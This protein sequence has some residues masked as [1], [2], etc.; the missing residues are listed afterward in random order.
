MLCVE[1]PVELFEILEVFS[2]FYDDVNSSELGTN[3]FISN[4]QLFSLSTVIK[5]KSLQ[6]RHFHLI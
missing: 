1:H 2:Q 5:L 3:S 4:D 6:Q